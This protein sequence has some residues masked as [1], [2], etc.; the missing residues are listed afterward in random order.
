MKIIINIDKKIIEIIEDEHTYDEE[1]K[2][3][4]AKHKWDVWCAG[5]LGAVPSQEYFSK[6]QRRKKL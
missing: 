2:K 1:R 5:A 3:R 6:K 4:L